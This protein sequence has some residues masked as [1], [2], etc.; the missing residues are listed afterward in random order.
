MFYLQLPFPVFLTICLLGTGVMIFLAVIRRK[1]DR[2]GLI[3]V[4]WTMSLCLIATAVERFVELNYH[5]NNFLFAI[6]FSFIV[7]MFIELTIMAISD[8][9]HGKKSSR[10]I[11]GLI[12]GW[13]SITLFLL[14]FLHVLH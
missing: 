5:Q 14:I 13:I 9:V 2:K 12:L 7:L 11:I 6:Q 4:Y 1:K 8:L 10:V 3:A